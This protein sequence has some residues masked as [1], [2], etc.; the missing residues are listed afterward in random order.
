M[1]DEMLSNCNSDYI[2]E[3][4]PAEKE[5]ELNKSVTIIGTLW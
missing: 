3:N 1:K 2:I 4:N 5:K